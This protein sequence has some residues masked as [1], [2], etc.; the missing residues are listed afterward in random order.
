MASRLQLHELVR[1]STQDSPDGLTR[2]STEPTFISG[3]PTFIVLQGVSKEIN[4]NNA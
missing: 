1:V 2:T 3:M 4:S